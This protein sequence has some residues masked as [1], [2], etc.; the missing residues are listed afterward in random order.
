MR[1]IDCHTHAFPDFL[2]ARAMDSLKA[3]SPQQQ[4]KLDGTIGGLLRSMDEAGIHASVVASIA[5]SEK[6]TS[7]I[8]RWSCDIQSERIIPFASVHPLSNEVQHQIRRIK[9]AGIRGIKLHPLYQDFMPVDPQAIECYQMLEEAGLI[10]LFHSGLDFGYPGDRRAVPHIMLEIQ[11]HVPNLKMI[12]A[13]LGGLEQ[14]DDFAANGLGSNVYIETSIADLTTP[15]AR[16]ILAKHTR[17]RILFGTDSPWD[18]QKSALE[19]VRAAV[20]D[21]KLLADIIS[22]NAVQL[23]GLK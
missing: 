10:V 6:Q 19:R 11:E 3:M 13:H 9:E 4:P 18:G 1:I 22:N 23:L 14:W 2:A 16:Q 8:L 12:L 7:N 21:E 15:T 5:T 20:T 17:G